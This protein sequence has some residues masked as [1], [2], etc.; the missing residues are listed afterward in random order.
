MIYSN[1]YDQSNDPNQLFITWIKN[2]ETNGF[3][4]LEYET[5]SQGVDAANKLDPFGTS[6][7]GLVTLLSNCARTLDTKVNI[8]IAKHPDKSKK[9]GLILFLFKG[10]ESCNPTEFS[11]YYE[12]AKNWIYRSENLNNTLPL[13]SPLDV[14]RKHCLH[15]QILAY[16]QAQVLQAASISQP[17]SFMIFCAE[18]MR[19]LMKTLLPSYSYEKLSKANALSSYEEDL[20]TLLDNTE[21]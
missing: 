8:Y 6:L 19:Q 4:A 15:S 5:N 16:S 14:D 2:L 12:N 20:L 21:V 13:Y 11:E 3:M 1:S 10:S 9:E 7:E 18:K 17:N